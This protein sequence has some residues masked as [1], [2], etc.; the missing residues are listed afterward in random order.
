MIQHPR[1]LV[2]ARLDEEAVACQRQRRVECQH[3][4]APPHA[5]PEDRKDNRCKQGCPDRPNDEDHHQQDDAGDVPRQE[6][7]VAI[8]VCASGEGQRA[9]DAYGCPRQDVQQVVR[10]DVDPAVHGERHQSQCRP[11]HLVEAHQHR[12][13]EATG[14]C[15]VTRREG[16][17]TIITLAVEANDAAPHGVAWQLGDLLF[18]DECRSAP[19]RQAL[20]YPDE[21]EGVQPAGGVEAADLEDATVDRP[22]QEQNAREAEEKVV[23]AP[24]PVQPDPL[25]Q[26]E[27]HR[28]QRK[29]DRRPG[30]DVPGM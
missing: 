11:M 12:T 24:A 9:G 6:H 17:V 15:S 25:L 27:C 20:E 16:V 14:S 4:Q 2:K 13:R 26:N 22:E 7:V 18:H 21:E 30:E 5:T 10:K 3:R 28:H 19:S 29:G 23:A 8:R 1:L